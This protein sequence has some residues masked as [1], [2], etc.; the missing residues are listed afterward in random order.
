[1]VDHVM[2]LLRSHVFG[3]RQIPNQPWIQIAGAS[4]HRHAR[5][6]REGHAG[7]YAFAAA[8]RR[9]ARPIAEM[10]QDHP[11]I[12]GLI[13][14]Y[15]RQLLHEERIR[16]TMKPIALYTLRLVASRYRQYP[17]DLRHIAMKSGVEACHLRQTWKSLAKQI[18]QG[19]LGR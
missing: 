3:L 19:K 1:M 18:D 16:Q 7:I 12:C 8:D 11:P 6:W 5:C 10:G 13:T 17:G 9:Q 15:A 14:V 4:A 2:K